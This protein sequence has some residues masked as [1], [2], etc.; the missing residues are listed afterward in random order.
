M[1]I[2]FLI[3]AFLFFFSHAQYESFVNSQTQLL[4]SHGLR[5]VKQTDFNHMSSALMPDKIHP[6]LNCLYI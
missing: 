3:L 6:T 5:E 1:K 2:L 4:T